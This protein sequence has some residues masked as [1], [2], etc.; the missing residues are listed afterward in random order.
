[1]A[2]KRVSKTTTP[3]V[4]T[5]EVTKQVS[6]KVSNDI[7]SNKKVNQ[8]EDDEVLVDDEDQE[9]SIESDKPEDD[10]DAT[11]KTIKKRQNPTKETVITS[12]DDLISSIE[13]DIEN[14]RDNQNKNKGIKFLRTLNKKIKSLKNQSSRLIKSRNGVKKNTNNNNSGFLKPVKISNEMAKFTGWDPNELKSRVDVTK[15]LCNYIRDNDLQNPKDR[16]QIIADSKL[17]KLLKYDAK[18]ETE[19]LTYFAIQSKLKGHFIKD[20]PITV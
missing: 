13:K 4:T 11:P 6:E 15:Y 20:A 7:K 19:P 16:R 2:N 14:I 1:M 18:K 12:F 8:K 17:S 10:S 3:A 5:T 9:D